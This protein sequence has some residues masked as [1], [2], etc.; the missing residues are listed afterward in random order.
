MSQHDEARVLEV[1]EQVKLLIMFAGM[2]VED[3]PMLKDVATD[4][5][6]RSS[7]ALTLAPVL[8]AV[9]MD[10]EEQHM[11]AEVRRKRAVALVNLVQVIADTEQD[12]TKF[13]QSQAAKQEAR[14]KLSG[15]LG[16]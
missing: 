7:M 10:Y 11:E 14:A 6:G 2:M 15:I 3:L 9:G 13:K 8:G 1:A 4:S 5:A 16:L 12:R